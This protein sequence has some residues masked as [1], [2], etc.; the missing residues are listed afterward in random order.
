MPCVICRSTAT[1][2]STVFRGT[3]PTTVKLC[4]PC[5]DKVR[6]EEQLARIKETH[7]HDLKM[8]AVDEFLNSV[9]L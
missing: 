1:F 2:K 6:A 9:G 3:S 8:A 5:A 7:G 4:R